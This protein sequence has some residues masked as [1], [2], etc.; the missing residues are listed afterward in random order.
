MAALLLSECILSYAERYPWSHYISF[1]CTVATTVLQ[2][3]MTTFSAG[4]DGQVR[5][6]NP[7]QGPNSV[8]VIGK[9]DQP[10]RCHSNFDK[11]PFNLMFFALV[12]HL[13]TALE[14]H[15]LLFFL[16]LLWPFLLRHSSVTSLSVTSCTIKPR[17]M[18]FLPSHNLLVTSSWD[19]SVISNQP[20]ELQ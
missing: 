16:L 9:H 14:L 6:W 1:K 18:K 4:C 7:S 12:L 2:D 19:K 8:Q 5:M 13:Y 20:L 11:A 3:G 15:R 17:N 10:V